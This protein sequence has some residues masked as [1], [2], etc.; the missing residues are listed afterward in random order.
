MQVQEEWDLA[1]VAAAEGRFDD[2]PSSMYIRNL[3]SFH[4][5]HQRALEA[6][7][8]ADNA[9][10]RNYWYYGSSGCGKSRTARDEFPDSQYRKA[11][12]KWWGGYQFEHVVIVDD[13]D[14]TH[15]S[16]I[17]AFLKEW[18]DHYRFNAEI[19]NAGVVIR[20][21]I[22]IVTSQYSIA[23]CFTDPET[24]SALTR[25]FT[26]RKFGRLPGESFWHPNIQ[27]VD[28]NKLCTPVP[29]DDHYIHDPDRIDP[30]VFPRFDIDEPVGDDDDVN[31]FFEEGE[32]E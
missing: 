24:V 27:P 7:V 31:D 18:S 4:K 29:S 8:P 30:F 20:P 26:M 10:L 6:A 11:K 21:K 23:D 14:P 2:I 22:L 32:D 1:R 17:G 28:I 25:R 9:C 13:V 19:K 12:N 16:W 5:I 3:A 15:Q